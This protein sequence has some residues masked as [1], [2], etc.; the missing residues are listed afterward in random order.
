MTY[1][2]NI[3]EVGEGFHVICV[4]LEG[5]VEVLLPFRIMVPHH[6][7]LTV[8]IVKSAGSVHPRAKIFKQLFAGIGMA[9][10]RI[11]FRQVIPGI[12]EG[13]VQPYGLFKICPRFFPFP[14]LKVN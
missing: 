7:I 14:P 9:C 6:K 4:N 13:L 5:P 10:F 3:S 12:K 1:R 11:E 2:F 8:S